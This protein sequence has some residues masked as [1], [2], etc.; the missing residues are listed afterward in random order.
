MNLPELGVKR[1][2]LTTVVF[3]LILIIGI[4]SL[5]NL[6]LELLPDFSYPAVSII[7]TY[8][9]A[10]PEEIE[11]SITKLIESTVALVPNVKNVYS[12]SE[13]GVSAV[14]VEFEWGTDIDEA[15]NDIRDK[16]DLIKDMLPDEASKPLLFKFSTSMMPILLI[17]VEADESYPVLYHLLKKKVVDPLKQVEGVGDAALTG[18]LIREIKVNV[19]QVKLNGYGL[20]INDV[21]NAIRFNNITQPGGKITIGKGDY[22]I[23]VLGEYQSVNEIKNV[24]VG[25]FRGTPVY[26]RDVAEVVDGFADETTVVRV[27]RKPGIMIWVQKQTKANSVEVAKR[28]KEK[29]EEI[30]KA[31]PPDVKLHV[32]FDSSRFIKKSINN[33][34]RT[35]MWGGIFVLIVVFLFLID[36]RASII[37]GL[38]IPFSLIVAFIF[39]YALGYT[40]N[41]TSLSSL[42]IAIG[43]VV[44]NGIVVTENIYRRRFEL[45]EDVRTASIRGAKEVMSAIIASTLT[46]V[47]IFIPILFVKGLIGILFKQL[48]LAVIA[49][50][51]ASL[52]VALFLS[53]MLTSRL[54]K[55][56]MRREFFIKAEQKNNQIFKKIYEVYL[57]IL[58]WALSHKAKTVLIAIGIFVLSLLMFSVIGKEFLPRT[59]ESRV[60]LVLELESGTTL[61]VTKKVVQKIEKIVKENVP[62][63]KSI[64]TRCGKSPKGLGAAAGMEEGDN[65]A[66]ISI[67]LVEKEKRKRSSDEIAHML[68]QKIKQ[69]PGVKSIKTETGGSSG[70]FGFGKPVEI[71]IYGYDLDKS[72]KFAKKIK[73]ILA[74]IKGVQ[75]I[76]INRKPGKPELQFRVN[77]RK[78]WSSGFSL[79]MIS[80]IVKNSFAGVTASKYK[81]EGEEYDIFVRLRKEDRASINN[82]RNLLIRRM[83]GKLISLDTL[84]EF[85]LKRGPKQIFRKNRERMIK[86]SADIFGKPLSQVEKEFEEKMKKVTVPSGIHYKFSGEIEQRRSTFSTL[87]LLV[88]LGILLVYLVMAGQFESFLDPFIIMGTVPF[89]VTGVAFALFFTGVTLNIISY[90]GIIMLVGIVVNNGIVLIDYI[91]RLRR[92]E[93][94]ELYEAIK[95]GSKTRLRPVLMTA[96]TT[97]FGMLP[98]ALSRGAGAELWVPLGVTIIS[99]LLFSTL[100]TLIFIPTVYAIVETRIKKS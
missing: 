42:A 39:L 100:V 72:F 17:G 16:L 14:T 32:I 58:S 26:L 76:T 33:L 85:I 65:I 59:D 18:G 70:A 25:N 43:M 60:R 83:D 62:E 15:A 46:T 5:A 41:I 28:C 95:Q 6:S 38:T 50:L 22:I 30:K 45:G 82:I 92:E 64:L 37:I 71:E 12:T 52:L 73:K 66:N 20:T 48:A 74:S 1:P 67:R 3:T 97:I 7:T 29:L 4:I 49:V 27:N 68:V 77:K 86:V 53:P 98:M 8:R 54:F 2:V 89:A 10:G 57:K 34:S 80:E 63:V 81:E 88:F 11:S 99:G 21:V 36:W 31:L 79:A 9:G 55:T 96:F 56:K 93:G 47:A 69:I 90:V 78:A 19:N 75:G 24:V 40:I 61:D 23:R 84:G 13:E 87:F 35:I 94:M 91:N 44:D 51:S